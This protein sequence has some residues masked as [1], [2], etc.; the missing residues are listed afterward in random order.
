[1]TRA[2]SENSEDPRDAIAS[3]R[4]PGPDYYEVLQW[5]HRE[6][7]PASYVELGVGYGESLKLA[8]PPTVALGIDP[9]PLADHP[10]RAETHIV[11]ATSSDFFA[12]HRLSDW[13]GMPHFNFAF[14][15]GLHLFDQV[16]DD[17]QHLQ[18]WADA[19]SIVA[20]HDTIPLDRESSARVR[21]TNFHTGDV[22]KTRLLLE[23]CRAD[24]VTLAIAPAGLTLLRGLDELRFDASQTAAIRDLDWEDYQRWVSRSASTP[25]S[26]PL[27][28]WVREC[29]PDLEIHP[30]PGGTRGCSDNRPR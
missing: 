8:L 10:W 20:I 9:W 22:W 27:A 12:S 3:A 15:D 17:L 28:R 4:F 21:T 29:R 1:M 24:C 30:Q 16:V 7:R 2:F 26:N 6:L 19:R 5:L 13:I 11:R 25:P 23:A 18:P 14:I